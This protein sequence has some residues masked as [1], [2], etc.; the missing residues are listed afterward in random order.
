MTTKKNKSENKSYVYV[1]LDTRKIGK[2]VYEKDEFKIEF[3]FEP[4]YLGKGTGGRIDDHMN[5]KNSSKSVENVI[6]EIITS[7]KKPIRLKIKEYISDEEAY[8]TEKLLVEKIGRKNIQT[9][10]LVNVVPGGDG[11]PTFSELPKDIQDRVRKEK[12]DFVKNKMKSGETIIIGRERAILQYSLKGIFLKRWKS[13]EQA[14]IELGIKNIATVCGGGGNGNRQQSGGFIWRYADENN[15]P[16]I[17]VI[18]VYHMGNNSGKVLQ[19]TTNG[20]FVKCFDSAYEINRVIGLNNSLIGKV[21]K[22][23]HKQAYGFIWRYSDENDNPTIPVI[24]IAPRRSINARIVYPKI[25]RS[26]V[27]PS[28]C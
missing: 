27:T 13:I 3:E 17:P 11:P 18:P 12:S 7:G 8:K 25:R 16:T 2:Y 28:L 5:F 19:F 21:C 9:G 14:T 22:G 26:Q 6:R 1:Y 4:F 15:N 20:K 10:P 24:P 23:T